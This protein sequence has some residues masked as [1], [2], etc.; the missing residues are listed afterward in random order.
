M[1]LGAEYRMSQEE[2]IVDVSTSRDASPNNYETPVEGR[3]RR[4]RREPV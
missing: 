2:N 1:K 4:N 3:V